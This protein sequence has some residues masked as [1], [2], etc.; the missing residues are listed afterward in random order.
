MRV[1]IAAKRAIDQ[2]GDGWELFRR[3]TN[4]PA[5]IRRFKL[6]GQVESWIGPA[7]A[8]TGTLI[9]GYG[10]IALRFVGLV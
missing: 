3:S 7:V 8:I 2:E 5:E 6:E 4:S 10:D 9:W 1:G